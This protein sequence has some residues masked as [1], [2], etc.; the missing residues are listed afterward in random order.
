MYFKILP[1]IKPY[2]IKSRHSVHRW[3]WI[4]YSYAVINIITSLS[5]NKK[6]CLSACFSN[7]KMYILIVGAKIQDICQSHISK[8]QS[9]GQEKNSGAVL[10]KLIKCSSFV[11][12]LMIQVSSNKKSKYYCEL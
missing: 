7:P 3:T 1:N 8:K 9:M 2:T 11:K 5:L 10:L 4:N 6:Y 12:I